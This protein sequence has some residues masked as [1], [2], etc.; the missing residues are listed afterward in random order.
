[1]AILEKIDFSQDIATLLRTGTAAAHDK[2]EHSEGAGW[3]VRGELDKEEYVRFLMMLYHVYDNLERALEKYSTHPVLAPTYNPALFNRTASLSADISHFLQ[4]PETSWSSHPIHVTLTTSP[5]EPFAAYTSRIQKL[6]D[7]NPA[8]LLAH[9]YVRYLGDLSGGQFIKRR[10]IKAYGL[11]DDG[12][13]V[14]FYEF[15]KL[16]GEA[17]VGTIGDMK[18]VK[19]WY[20]KGMNEGVGEDED[21]KALIL[22]EANVAFELNTGLFT[23]L[24]APSSHPSHESADVP[25]LGDPTSPTISSSPKPPPP[26]FVTP[27]PNPLQLLQKAETKETEEDLPVKEKGMY[28]ISSVIA[29]ILALCL[30]HFFLVT[31]GFTGEKGW[32]KLEAVGKWVST[33]VFGTYAAPSQ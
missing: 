9:A 31:G 7:S 28:P 15:G 12:R 3:L 13:G 4:L 8:A 19:E 27:A 30:S 33:N 18:K 24:R 26:E 25:V 23:T 16:G 5:P 2:A 1:M 22:E 14:A 20:R 11:E 17:G 29:F 10:I 32:A 6:A 21:I